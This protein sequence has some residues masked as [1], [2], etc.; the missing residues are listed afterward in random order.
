MLNSV[1]YSFS[2]IW[3]ITIGE[4]QIALIAFCSARGKLITKEFN[5]KKGNFNELSLFL[6]GYY[7][8]NQ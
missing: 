8:M 5:K 6:I 1:I 7:I 4:V 2:F 3:F